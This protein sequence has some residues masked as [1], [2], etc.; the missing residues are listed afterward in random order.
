WWGI[1]V[2]SPSGILVVWSRRRPPELDYTIWACHYD[3]TTRSPEVR[4]DGDSMIADDEPAIA[5]DSDG[6]PWVVWE[7]GDAR[8]SSIFCNR[9]GFPSALQ[10]FT[11]SPKPKAML[12]SSGPSRTPVVTCRLPCGNQVRVS[13]YDL[14]GRQVRC[15]LNEHR[16]EG[17]FA[18]RWDGTSD[19][20]AEVSSGVYV[21]RLETGELSAS[22]R[23]IL[24]AHKE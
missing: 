1:A 10:E 24:L 20:G 18:V 15:L 23:V 22:S 14:A 13:I 8:G 12:S 11:S 19:Q 9:Y 4:I 16:P 5:F 7:G 21:C 2:S 3:G 17:E 6:F